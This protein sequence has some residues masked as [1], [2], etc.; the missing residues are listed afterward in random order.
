MTLLTTQQA[1]DVLN[2]SHDYL[3]GLL[4]AGVLVELPCGGL[5]EAD[6]LS[7]KAKRR[8]SRRAALVKLTQLTEEWGLY[9]AEV[10]QMTRIDRTWWAQLAQAARE[11]Q[12][13]RNGRDAETR[14]RELRREAE[15]RACY[16]RAFVTFPAHPRE[17]VKRGKDTV[18]FIVFRNKTEQEAANQFRLH[19]ESF[20]VRVTEASGLA[21]DGFSAETEY[22]AN[23]ADV[24]GKAG[25]LE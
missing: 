14:Q 4:D 5:D 24:L 2:V 17:A 10:Q 12:E 15:I 20:G 6:V 18:C 21:A 1:A 13:A 11:G 9:D 19:L 7:Y 3:M 22:Y 23:V 8:E 16:D 25:Q